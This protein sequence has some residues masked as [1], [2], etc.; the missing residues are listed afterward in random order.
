MSTHENDIIFDNL[1]EEFRDTIDGEKIINLIDY[2]E[3][4]NIDE[5]I[6]IQMGEAY[7]LEVSKRNELK[8]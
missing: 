5:S 8:K 1:Y 6:M 4:R 3:D 2:M 7:I